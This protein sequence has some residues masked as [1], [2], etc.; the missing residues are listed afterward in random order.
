MGN[1]HRM[2][3]V[4][5][6]VATARNTFSSMIDRDSKF[7]IVV[8]VD[9][10]KSEGTHWEEELSDLLRAN[11][12]WVSLCNPSNKKVFGSMRARKTGYLHKRSFRK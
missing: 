11:A 8:S 10:I 3:S 5:R 2:K 4:Q 12:F 9:S 6:R 7:L 1:G